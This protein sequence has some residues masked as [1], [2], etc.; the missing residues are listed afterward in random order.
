MTK[1]YGRK[2]KENFE[3]IY[4]QTLLLVF[5][6]MIFF[7]EVKSFFIYSVKYIEGIVYVNTKPRKLKIRI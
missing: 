2:E 1:R 6:F 7:V 5:N 4:I 3:N